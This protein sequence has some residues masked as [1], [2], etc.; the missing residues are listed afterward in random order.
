MKVLV[1]GAAGRMGAHL[2]RLLTLE[3]HEVRALVLPDDP[4]NQQ[5]DGPG[6]RFTPGAWRTSMRSG[7]RSKG[8]A[9]S[10]RSPA[11]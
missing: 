6:W 1:T 10:L 3:G 9:R 4:N 11:R 2:T 8:S 5:I 7:G